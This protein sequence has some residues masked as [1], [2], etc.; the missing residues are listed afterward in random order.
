M[1]NI[2][3]A[4]IEGR[5]S[6]S[7]L[8]RAIAESENPL[9]ARAQMEKELAAEWAFKNLFATIPPP[10][11]GLSKVMAALKSAPMP[12]ISPELERAFEAIDQPLR[13][14]MTNI[15]EPA[16]GFEAALARVKAKLAAAPD[17]VMETEGDLKIGC[18]ETPAAGM[19]LVEK[20]KTRVTR[21]VVRMPQRSS[22]LRDVLAAGK[23]LPENPNDVPDEKK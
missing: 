15:P 16:G 6:L 17:P 20:K 23:D 8:E 12:K 3:K 5:G 18:D 4:F 14:S 21:K 11:V 22:M 7:S 1:S 9:M 2:V 13:E 19:S 10:P